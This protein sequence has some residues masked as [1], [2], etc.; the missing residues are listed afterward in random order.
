MI[1]GCLWLV[2]AACC[3][4]SYGK[5]EARGRRTL[6]ALGLFSL[7]FGA[8]GVLGAV[9][10]DE[11]L[12][13]TSILVPTGMLCVGCFVT[14]A[15]QAVRCTVQVS[16]V[17][18][19]YNRYSGGK[20]QSAY[21]PVFAYTFEGQAYETQ[22]SVSYSLK[23]VQKKFVIGDSYDIFI[24][25]DYPS[26]CLGERKVPPGHYCIGAAGVLV[27]VCYAMFLIG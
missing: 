27:L 14:V 9:L 2:C 8:V 26:K 15:H 4:F 19:S 3:M 25:P 11:V 20:G 22:Q 7:V 18:V 10:E 23:R 13:I 17:C 5:A 6:L 24:R 12:Q 16:A 21:A 1:V